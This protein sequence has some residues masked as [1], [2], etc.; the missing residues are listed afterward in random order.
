ME[1]GD[2]KKSVAVSL[3]VALVLMFVGFGCSES[4]ARKRGRVEPIIDPRAYGSIPDRELKARFA[5]PDREDKVVVAAKPEVSS[6]VVSREDEIVALIKRLEDTW[7]RKDAPGFLAV[8]SE[9]AKIMVG[10]EE[11]IMSKEEYKGMFPDL[12]TKYGAIKY[13]EPEIKLDGNRADVKVP[14]V[15]LKI[16]DN[17]WF[18]RKMQLIYINGTWLIERSTYDVHFKG[19]GGPNRRLD[20]GE[21]ISD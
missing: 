4:S 21:E 10:K 3:V 11:R 5:R 13:K 20:L 9:D 17:V 6:A 1:R 8:F 12:F 15:I 7:N 2:I 19:P 18:L 14:C 16:E